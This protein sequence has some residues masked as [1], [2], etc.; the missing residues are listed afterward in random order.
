[1]LPER[2]RQNIELEIELEVSDWVQ[3]SKMSKKDSQI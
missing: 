2:N 3:R 1:M